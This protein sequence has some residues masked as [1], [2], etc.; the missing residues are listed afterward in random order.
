MEYALIIAARMPSVPR[1]LAEGSILPMMDS[2]KDSQQAFWQRVIVIFLSHY[3]LFFWVTSGYNASLLWCIFLFFSKGKKWLWF[4][5][6]TTKRSSCNF[7]L[8]P[9][10]DIIVISAFLSSLPSI[11][12]W[13]NTSA[14]VL[15]TF[16][17]SFMRRTRQCSKLNTKYWELTFCKQ[18]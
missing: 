1:F 9:F 12:K 3:F 16:Y 4:P 7:L 13:Y 5:F 17:C 2:V 15:L 11:M 6:K 14:M 8:K 18:A 10:Q